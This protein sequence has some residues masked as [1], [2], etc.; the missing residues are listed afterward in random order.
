MCNKKPNHAWGIRRQETSQGSGH[1]CQLATSVV[2]RVCQTDN[3]GS[4]SPTLVG[5]QLPQPTEAGRSSASDLQSQVGSPA[6]S[7][8]LSPDT[9]P[10]DTPSG[11][12]TATQEGPASVEGLGRTQPF[13]APAMWSSRQRPRH[14]RAVTNHPLHPT[15]RGHRV[16][17][18]KSAAVTDATSCGVRCSTTINLGAAEISSRRRRAPPHHVQPRPC[19]QTPMAAGGRTWG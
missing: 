2:N 3:Q 15:M 19:D 5:F 17:P 16:G 12:P 1:S 4:L 13:Q 7:F 6:P 14:R 11:K 10:R 18:R 9:A 8:R